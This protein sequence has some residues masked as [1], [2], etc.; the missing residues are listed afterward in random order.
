[1]LRRHLPADRRRGVILMVVLALLTLFA[2]VGITFAFYAQKSHTASVN[3]REAWQLGAQGQGADIDPNTLLNWALAQLIYDVPDDVTGT[4][5]ALRGHSLARTAY[6]YNTATLNTQPFNGT[7]RLHYPSKFG[8]DDYQLI[9]YTYFPS[10]TFVRDPERYQ[11][12]GDPTK[13]QTPFT[14]GANAPYTY[15]DLNSFFLAAARA[16]GTQLTQ[17]FHR[18]WL[19]NATT[20]LNNP[21]NPNWKN[22]QGKY[23]TARPRPNDQLLPGETSIQQIAPGQWMAMPTRRPIFPYPGDATGDIKSKIGAP[24]GNDS[25]WMDMGYPVITA[26]DG[27]RFK[28]MFAWR[29]EDLDGKGNVNTAGNLRGSGGIHASNQGWGKWEMSLVPFFNNPP[30]E[31]QNLFLGNATASLAGRYGPDGNPG[32]KGS[33]ANSGKSPRFFAQVDYDGSNELAGGAVTAKMLLPN[34]LSPFPLFPQGYGNG[35]PVERTN[36]PMQYDYFRPAGSALLPSDDTVLPASDIKN[37]LYSGAAGSDVMNAIVAQLCPQNFQ[38]N[39]RLQGLITTLSMDLDRMGL[40]PWVYSRGGLPP[41]PPPSIPYGYAAPGANPLFQ[42]PSTAAVAFPPLTARNAATPSNS[43]FSQDWRAVFATLEK[44]DLRQ[45]P[46]SYPHQSGAVGYFNRFDTNA[47]W[48]STPV[49]QQFTNAQN[50]RQNLADQ[51]YRRLLIVTGAPQPAILAMPT[52]AELTVLRWLGQ[53]AV[54]IVDYIDE[55]EIS[56]PFNFYAT[57]YNFFAKFNGL[58]PAQQQLPASAATTTSLGAQN[59]AQ[60]PEQV[61]SYWVFGT[62]LP[63]V[64]LN[65]V[66]TEYTIPKPTKTNPN[67]Q[68]SVNVWTELYCPFPQGPTNPSVQPQDNAAAPGSSIPLYVAAAGAQAAYSPY[69]VVLANTNTNAGGPLYVPPAATTE[70]TLGTP[71]QVRSEAPV[72]APT[73]PLVGGGTT[74]TAIPSGT[75][76]LVGSDNNDVQG[77]INSPRVPANTPWYKTA[78]MRYQVTFVP[79]TSTWKIGGLTGTPINDQTTGITVLL[80]RLANP[81]LPEDPRPVLGTGPTSTINPLYNPYVTVDYLPALPLNDSSKATKGN[82][83][84]SYGKLQPYASDKTTGIGTPKSQVWPNKNA[85]FNGKT[86]VQHTFGLQNTPNTNP[87]TWLTHLDRQPNNPMELLQVSGFRPWQLTQQFIVAKTPYQHR[88][89]WFDEDLTGAN[90]SQSHL[91]YRLFGFLETADRAAGVSR[92]GRVP[93]RINLNTVWDPEVLQALL[94]P[95]TS[96]YFTSNDV[97][98]L[99][100]SLLATRTP[101]LPANNTAGGVIGATDRPFLDAAAAFLPTTDVQTTL[102][103][104]GAPVGRG[105]KDTIFRARAPGGANGTVRLFTPAAANANPY[106]QYEMLTKLSN[107]VTTRSNVFGVWLTVGFFQVANDQTTPPKLGPEIGY[108]NTNIRHSFF[109]VVDRTQVV[110]APSL[111]TSTVAVPVPAPG[112]APTPPY[113]NQTVTVTP[114]T[115][116]KDPFNGMNGTITYAGATGIGNTVNWSIQPGS[117]L[118]ID[119]GTPNEEVVQVTQLV[120]PGKPP[121]GFTADFQREHTAGFSITMHGNPGPQPQFDPTQPAYAPVVPYFIVL[122]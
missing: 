18:K 3:F 26:P 35:S 112:P 104:G 22:P 32:K 51:I 69:K 97:T 64:V 70:N 91:L 6:G 40:S 7:G 11:S 75:Y 81:H 4:G 30:N 63:P 118:V 78:N 108:P 72:T 49:G 57:A 39:P 96:N 43:D 29:V 19:F 101:G 83:E 48:L 74:N 46:P 58:P 31:L 98:T 28:P 100:Q 67:P 10:D 42:A 23:L 76:F 95:Q 85:A 52:A 94:D 47:T 65:E 114:K 66:N 106:L 45:T 116:A 79:A 84:T 87:A 2:I 113:T 92:F 86:T 119:R 20:N 90:A 33:V 61:F 121:T 9:N 60:P 73:A 117:L 80:R 54:N 93:G 8:Q 55:D 53:L 82:P 71:D 14:G 34:G 105:I 41:I 13:P 12:R 15:P 50:Y 89:Q 88:T 107:N 109:A 62:E 37:L 59:T 38:N 115:Q 36:H 24:G 17:S 21:N 120:P 16:D 110:L 56:T 111:T 103:N 99:W 1:M 25:I 77:T 27:T 122:Q 5:S 44:I 102:P 68:F